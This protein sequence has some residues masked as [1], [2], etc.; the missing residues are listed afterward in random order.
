MTDNCHPEAMIGESVQKIADVQDLK[1]IARIKKAPGKKYPM[2]K[3]IRTTGKMLNIH[4]WHTHPPP[5]ASAWQ[6]DVI[7]KSW[8]KNSG[9]VKWI[10]ES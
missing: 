6:K 4:T 9:I 2:I 1:N 3:Q 5:C 8:I 7:L 10:T